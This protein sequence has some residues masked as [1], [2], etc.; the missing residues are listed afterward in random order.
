MRGFRP[1]NRRHLYFKQRKSRSKQTMTVSGL[2]LAETSSVALLKTG[3]VVMEES[4]SSG[5]A[6][7][8][9]GSCQWPL[10]SQAAPFVSVAIQTIDCPRISSGT[11]HTTA[12]EGSTFTP[13][14]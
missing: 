11:V 4:R 14:L 10:G 5:I 8:D 13:G 2:D 12:H 6:L 3:C 9:Y 1:R 7:L